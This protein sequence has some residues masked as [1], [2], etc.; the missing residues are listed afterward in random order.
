MNVY[1]N[2]VIFI[3][4]FFFFF[5]IF[6]IFF[7]FIFF[8]FH[9]FFFIHTGTENNRACSVCKK[10]FSSTGNRRKHEKQIHGLHQNGTI[11]SI[12]DANSIIQGRLVSTW[13]QKGEFFKLFSIHS[14]TLFLTFDFVGVFIHYFSFC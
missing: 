8:I 3:F 4:P 9:F 5:F 7:L 1:N 13:T 6:Y 12:A 2:S 14:S 11:R 10:L